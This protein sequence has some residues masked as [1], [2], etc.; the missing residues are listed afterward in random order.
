MTTLNRHSIHHAGVRPCSSRRPNW[1]RGCRILIATL[2]TLILPFQFAS[3]EERPNI[4]LIVADDMGYG[5]LSC[6][7]SKQ[8]S[9]PNIDSLAQ[10][11]IRCSNGYVS[12][13]VCAPSRAGLMTGRY[14]N[15]FGFEHNIVGAADY[16]NGDQIGLPVEETTMA[17]QLKQLGYSTACIGKWHLGNHPA[18]HPNSRGF[19]YYFGRMKGHGYFPKVDDQAI[20]RQRKPVTK[21][22]VPYTTDWYTKE[23]I[24]FI[25][26]TPDGKPF[27]L[28]LAHDTPH[29]PLQAKAEDLARYQTISN[30]KRRTIC[31]MQ[32]CLDENVGK[33]VQYLK[34]A[35]RYQNT[36]VVFLSDNGGVTDRANHSINAPLRGQ[37]AT[38]LEGGMRVPFIIS[39]PAGLLPNGATYNHPIISLDLLPTFLS[40][41]QRKSELNDGTKLAR[42]FDGVNL[43]P[44]LN[45]KRGNKRPHKDLYW[46]ITHR[47]AAIRSGDWKLV[48]TPHL[49]PQ[50]YNLASDISERND[51]AASNPE[52]VREL[53]TR[54]AKWESSFKDTP[55]W[56]SDNRWMKT[57]FEKYR[58]NY[59]LTQPE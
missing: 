51:L 8:I 34:D 28:Y 36:V 19:D 23:A 5:D 49:P 38:F 55:R 45:G 40:V 59:T 11:G 31:A 58:T 18:M 33:L 37:K 13:V 25:R 21:I 29:T 32:H 7:G 41:A 12:G 10:S 53:M 26:R 1:H 47:G 2:L 39:W 15:R 27:F 20:Y 42:T 17:D 9:T 14:Q 43:L 24:E 48:R 52:Q 16:Y 46:R 50:L 35:K 3:A 54:L 30:K 22:E 56:L 4:V 6:Y 44:F 57:I